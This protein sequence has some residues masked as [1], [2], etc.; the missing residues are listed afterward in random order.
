MSAVIAVVAGFLLCTASF[1][2]ISNAP[3]DEKYTPRDDMSHMRD[4]E[5]IIRVDREG[6]IEYGLNR[7]DYLVP[8]GR[9]PPPDTLTSVQALRP[10]AQLLS[11]DGRWRL[12]YQNDGDLAGYPTLPGAERAF[13]TAGAANAAPGYAAVVNGSLSLY[14]IYNVRYWTA[15]TAG[16]GIPP[17]YRLVMQNDR[18]IVVYDSSSNATWAS[19]TA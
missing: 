16:K 3:A 12:V 17:Y 6:V 19:N 4:D 2:A 9:R 18:N 13:W 11:E 7:L 8:D 15:D 10:R 1:A 5:V 14:D